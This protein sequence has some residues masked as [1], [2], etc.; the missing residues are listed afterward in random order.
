VG[1]SCRGQEL[2]W[3]VEEPAPAPEVAQ[4]SSALHAEEEPTGVTCGAAT[5]WRDPRTKQWYLLVTLVL[6]QPES[7]L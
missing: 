5:L 1:R 2:P 6:P 3:A 7:V 4:P